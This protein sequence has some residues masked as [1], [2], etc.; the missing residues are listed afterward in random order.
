MTA[1]MQARRRRVSIHTR[2]FWRVNQALQS[3]SRAAEQRFNPHPPFLAGE[4]GMWGGILGNPPVSIH[5]RHFWRVN[6]AAS[7]KGV[8]AGQM[9]QSTP[10]ISGG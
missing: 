8:S 7:F 2:H 9:F 4:S 3:M 6:P 10:A 1:R 5:T